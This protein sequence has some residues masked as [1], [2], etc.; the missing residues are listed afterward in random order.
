MPRQRPTY[1]YQSTAD[2]AWTGCTRS[3]PKRLGRLIF[4]DLD[5]LLALYITSPDVFVLK[6]AEAAR[7][8]FTSKLGK[9]YYT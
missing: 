9:W 7:M 6:V 1:H 4:P 8:F 2:G 5:R 3:E